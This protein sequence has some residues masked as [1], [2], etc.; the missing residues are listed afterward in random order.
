M[1]LSILYRWRAR[2]QFFPRALRNPDEGFAEIPARQHADEG[3]RR[4]F[5][6]VDNVFAIA[7]IAGANSRTDLAQEGVIVIVDEFGVD[8]SA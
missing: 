8:V 4:L 2:R 3:C 1:L 5:E 6:T 7:N